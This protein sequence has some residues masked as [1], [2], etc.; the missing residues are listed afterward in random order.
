MMNSLSKTEKIWIAIVVG[1]AWGLA[2]AL[3]GMYMRNTVAYGMTGS[4]MTGIVVLVLAF[5]YGAI[6][7]YHLLFISLA[8]VVLFKL[9]DAWLLHLPVVHG[10]VGNPIF[11]IILEALAFVLVINVIRPELKSKLHGQALI[12][13]LYALIAVSV[14]PLVRYFTGLPACV[15]KGTNY[16]LSLYYSWLAISISVVTYPIGQ[17]LGERLTETL[18]AEQPFAVA[19]H[20]RLRV[21]LPGMAAALLVIAIL[22]RL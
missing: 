13:A 18:T 8:M 15:V 17:F 7:Q 6:R 1:A 20:N 5:G 11:A 22:I 19:L 14:F 3:V 12:G 10:A 9:L 4:I 2:E 21:V 16:P